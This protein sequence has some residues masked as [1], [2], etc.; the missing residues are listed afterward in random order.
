MSGEA[1][2]REDAIRA[3]MRSFRDR[4]DRSLEIISDAMPTVRAPHVALSGGKDSTVALHLARTIDPTIPALWFDDELE[5]DGTVEFVSLAGGDYLTIRGWRSLTGMNLGRGHAG[6]FLPWRNEP[7]WRKPDPR[8][9]IHEDTWWHQV[10]LL[11]GFDATITGVRASESGYRKKH[12]AAHGVTYQRAHGDTVI[13][14]L[15]RWNLEDV[16]AYIAD[17]ELP[18]HPAYDAMAMAGIE[19]K[20]QRVG[21]LPLS[22]RW[23]LAAVDRTLPERLEARYGRMWG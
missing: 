14:P 18:Y 22:E 6:W 12:V 17:R 20:L 21:P 9:V 13:Q 1:L 19:R 16:W 7:Y 15:A 11:A 3:R 23:I 2:R 5:Y 4:V 10:P 8:M